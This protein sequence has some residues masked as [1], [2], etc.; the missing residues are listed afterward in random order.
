MPHDYTQTTRET[1]RSSVDECL[2]AAEGL[3]A[4]AVASVDAPSFDATMRPIEL[5]GAAMAAGYG[6]SAFMSYV[7]LRVSSPAS[8][9]PRS[10]V[11]SWRPPASRMRK[12]V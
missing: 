3:I 5:A 10:N 6:T 4:Q 7:H 12:L 8:V 9:P 1:V 11:T 2:A